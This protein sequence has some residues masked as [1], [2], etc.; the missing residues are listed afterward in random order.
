MVAQH[1]DTEHQ[2]RTVDAGSLQTMLPRI[3]DLFDEPYADSSA[4]PTVHVSEA[5]RESVKAV[6]SGDGGDEVFAGYRRYPRW[7]GR[8]RFDG[9]PVVVRR[10]LAPLVHALLP[11]GARRERLIR[12]LTLPP[13]ERYGALVGLFSPLEKRKVL[14]PDFVREFGDYDDYWFLRQSWREDLDPLTRLQYVDLKTYLPDDILTKVDRASVSC[15]V[16]VRPPLLDHELVEFVF[17]IPT[18]LRAPENRSKF[19]LRRAVEGLVPPEVI[20]RSK[21]GFGVPNPWWLGTE[22]AWV[23]D[24]LTGTDEAGVVSPN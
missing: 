6:L 10:A 4:I 19:V 17:A 18:K 1:L 12:D 15:S 23:E 7:F 14:C 11:N 5:A 2:E 9:V 21:Q 24:A 20:D 8:S 22:R 3:V 13:L 16:E